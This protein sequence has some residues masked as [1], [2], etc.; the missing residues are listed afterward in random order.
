MP[1]FT[2]PPFPCSHMWSGSSSLSSKAHAKTKSPSKFRKF[3]DLPKQRLTWQWAA[4]TW[5]T[6]QSDWS[7][8][9]SP[10]QMVLPHAHRADLVGFET[11]PSHVLAA[12]FQ[13]LQHPCLQT[14]SAPEHCKCPQKESRLRQGLQCSCS[15]TWL[16]G[17]RLPVIPS[18]H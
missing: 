2:R 4:Q 9:L 15:C 10:E 5:R 3:C 11:F 17:T 16:H 18:K 14:S 13:C 12:L 6:N 7:Q 1:P 8:K